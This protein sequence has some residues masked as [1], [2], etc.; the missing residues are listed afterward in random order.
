METNRDVLEIYEDIFLNN[1]NS[2]NI[3]ESCEQ[4]VVER[5][6]NKRITNKRIKNITNKIKNQFNNE[7]ET[8]KNEI[9]INDKINNENNDINNDINNDNDIKKDQNIEPELILF[10]QIKNNLIK[11]NNMKYIDEIQIIIDKKLNNKYRINEIQII[12]D[13][14]NIKNISCSFS[15]EL[16][17][18][19]RIWKTSLEYNGNIEIGIHKYKQNSKLLAAKYAIQNNEDIKKFAKKY[20]VY[21]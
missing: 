5:T 12:N 1:E 4:I 2:E 11:L 21:I 7:K 3:D 16:N 6:T 19:N 9:I 17:E 10:N 20:L 14:F 18:T 8:I 13:Y 15:F